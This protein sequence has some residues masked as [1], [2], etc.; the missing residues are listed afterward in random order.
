ML[1]SPIVVLEPRA[2]TESLF[3]SGPRGLLVCSDRSEEGKDYAEFC[4]SLGVEEGTVAQWIDSCVGGVIGLVSG[5]V[6][7]YY[8]SVVVEVMLW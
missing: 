5:V 2:W 6:G 7:G 8:D 4:A 1:C 3:R